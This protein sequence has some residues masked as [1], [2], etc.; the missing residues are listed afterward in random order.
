MASFNFRLQK[1]LDIRQQKEEESKRYFKEAQSAKDKVEN[2]L[3]EM[4]GNYQKYNT[5]INSEGLIEQKIRKNYLQALNLSINEKTVELDKKIIILENKREDLKQK[6]I[7][8]KTVEILK[9]KKRMEFMD[10][11]NHI[12]QAQN[13]EFALYAHI[14][15]TERR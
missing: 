14:R 3:N 15:K 1:L 6:Q 8:R 13:D 4:K 12:E 9:E 2:D 5:I 7:D 11:Q 10:I